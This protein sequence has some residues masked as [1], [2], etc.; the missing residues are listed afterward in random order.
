MCVAGQ[1]QEAGE[2]SDADDVIDVGQNGGVVEIDTTR[3]PSNYRGSCAGAGPERILRIVLES[4]VSMS[5]RTSGDEDG[6]RTDSVLYVRRECDDSQSEV[7]CNDDIAGNGGGRPS[8]FSFVEIDRAEP[9]VYYIFADTFADGARFNVEVDV[10]P[11]EAEC[12]Q[13]DDCEGVTICE[14]S[15]CVSPQCVRDSQCADNERCLGGRCEPRADFCTRDADCDDPSQICEQQTCIGTNGACADV[16]DCPNNAFCIGGGCIQS[17]PCA[18]NRQCR[19]IGIPLLRCRQ[20]I[21]AS[22]INQC[23]RNS[24]CIA[25]NSCAFGF[26]IPSASPECVRDIHCAA[27]Q[28]CEGRVCVLE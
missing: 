15:F 10:S 5:V 8:L 17:I 3:A 1:C 27:N 13:D 14:E 25:G 24:D 16:D 19:Q 11:L 22:Q 6:F 9:G 28:V 26:C 7:V 20:G 21:C 12:E 4:F 18:N 2:C 23:N